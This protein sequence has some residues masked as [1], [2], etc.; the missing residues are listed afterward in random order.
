MN[1]WISK[2]R[3]TGLVTTSY[4]DKAEDSPG[5][6]PGIPLGGKGKLP[7][8]P[9]GAISASNESLDVNLDKCIQCFCCSRGTQNNIQWGKGYEW[10]KLLKGKKWGG[11]EK[12]FSRS[13]NI[14]VVDAG[15][16]GA[17]LSEIEQLNK[18]YYNMHRL[19]F[20]L[21]ATP[22]DADVLLVIGPVTDHM[23][24]CLKK[25]YEAMPNPKGVIAAGT[26]ALS[27][28]IFGPSF[29]CGEGVPGIIP[30]DI[31]IPGCPPPPLALLHG[32]LLI[33]NRTEKNLRPRGGEENA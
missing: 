29:A 9:T 17:C 8:C 7:D 26:C 1:K 28:G 2:G 32:L 30:V 16:C 20:F 31:L 3:S 13:L 24:L 23:R 27:G 19:G 14:R 33:T 4:P 11:A 10:A 25:V 18:P 6:S 5:V 21:T 12:A 22:R 15:E